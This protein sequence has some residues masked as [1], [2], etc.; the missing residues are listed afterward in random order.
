MSRIFEALSKASREKERQT[1]GE[2]DKAQEVASPAAALET[3]PF[4]PERIAGQNGRH[5]EIPPAVAPAPEP[6]RSWRDRL[7]E[8]IYGW[9]LRRYATHPIVALEEESSAA[10][11]YKILREQ[12]KR[13]RAEAGIRTVAITSPVKKDGKT[14]VAV[15]LA[16][17]IALAY[18][19]KVILIDA[20]LRAPSVHRYFN[21]DVSLGLTDYLASSSTVRV[22]DII[23]NT[24]LNGLRILP[25]GKPSR[26][27]SELLA[28]EKMRRL[29]EEIHAELPGHVVI[30]DSPPVLATPDPLVLSRQVDGVIV[31]VRAGKTPKEYLTK[32]L[33]VLDPNK[34]LGVV[35]NGADLGFGSK[36]YYYYSRNG[37]G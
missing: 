20:D 25:A 3:I 11:Q 17:A 29:L 28:K 30:M 32:A 23:C 15:N 2:S 36:Y 13:L 19:E 18:E 34:V 33:S 12:L 22:K 5:Y 35:L 26:F 37:R 24:H 16:A 4:D 9:D 7:E 31:I 10:E 1:E 21:A 27:A 14:T 8:L 6:A